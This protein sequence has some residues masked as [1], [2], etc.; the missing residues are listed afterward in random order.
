MSEQWHFLWFIF[1]CQFHHHFYFR[2]FL[3]KLRGSVKIER[4]IRV[5]LISPS[6]ASKVCWLFFLFFNRVL[7]ELQVVFARDNRDFT[8]C[9]AVYGR[10]DPSLATWCDD[11]WKKSLRRRPY[12]TLSR[13]QRPIPP[14]WRRQL[15]PR[16]WGGEVRSW[17][18][19]LCRIEVRKAP[20]EPYVR[21]LNTRYTLSQLKVTVTD[22]RDTCRPFG[23]W[24]FRTVD[25]L[26][27]LDMVRLRNFPWDRELQLSSIVT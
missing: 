14:R 12:L 7:A 13:L 1:I 24:G 27:T 18:D 20:D 4:N 9:S 25:W 21:F 11:A 16:Y 26:S 22:V 5:M 3:E 19:P 17:R 8:K 2:C 6:S 10:F 15:P 23:L